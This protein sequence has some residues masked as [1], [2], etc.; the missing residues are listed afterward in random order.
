MVESQ[1]RPEKLKRTVLLWRL[2]WLYSASMMAVCGISGH[3]DSI[4]FLF[5][6]MYVV[7]GLSTAP[8]R[9]SGMFPPSPRARWALAVIVAITS[10][11]APVIRRW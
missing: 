10:T 3:G 11:L 1:L 2:L 4:D 7:I 9:P 5:A 8:P 6:V